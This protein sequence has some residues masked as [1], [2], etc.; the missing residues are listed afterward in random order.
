[1]F[2]FYHTKTTDSEADVAP[3]RAHDGDAVLQWSNRPLD[4]LGSVKHLLFLEI[5][6][7]QIEDTDQVL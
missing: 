7:T 3:M 4:Q 6:E 2:S 5:T 1:M